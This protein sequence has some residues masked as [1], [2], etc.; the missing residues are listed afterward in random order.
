MMNMDIRDEITIQNLRMPVVGWQ[1]QGFRASEDRFFAGDDLK[2]QA[3]E[4]AKRLAQ[5]HFVPME[6]LP[7][8]PEPNWAENS[9]E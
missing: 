6:W 9:A 3:G 7:F 5:R 2:D 8:Q 4:Y 1:V